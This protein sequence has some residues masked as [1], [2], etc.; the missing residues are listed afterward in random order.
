MLEDSFSIKHNN[1]MAEIDSKVFGNKKL[2]KAEI[3]AGFLEE[4]KAISRKIAINLIKE[5]WKLPDLA[6]D[7]NYVNE[8]TKKIVK[9]FREHLENTADSPSF[10]QH[11]I[12]RE[13]PDCE[14][15]LNSITQI[16]SSAVMF[17]SMEAYVRKDLWGQDENG[18]AYLRHLAKGYPKNYIEHYIT[19]PGDITLLP[20]DEAQ[21]IIDKFGFT[22]AKL[23]LVFAAHAMNQEKPWESQFNLKV[24]DII[25]EFGWDKNHKKSKAEKLREIA[26]TAFALDCLLV[27][28]VWVEGRNRKG[29]IIASAPVGRMWNI[30][31]KPTGQLNLDGEI[32]N[33]NDIYITVQPGLWTRD[34]LNRAGAIS[35]EALYQFGYLA[36]QVLKIDPYHNELALRLAIFLTLDSRVRLN[37]NYTVQELL[38]IAFPKPVIAQARQKRR[39]AYDL[40]QCWDSAIKLLIQLDW[41][42]EFD[43]TTYPEELR[44]DSTLQNPRG[45]L[46]ILLNARLTIKPPAP[47]PELL[48]AKATPKL[49]PS[50]PS[51]KQKSTPST[52][53]TGSQV[54]EA[55][56]AKGWSQAQLAGFLGVSQYLISLIERGQRPINQK[57]EPKIRK[58]LEI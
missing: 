16:P 5:N 14:K 30:Y 38:E 55:R 35:R 4:I 8:L 21:Q 17:S 32:D 43:S 49:E 11:E 1:L 9:S 3:E 48:T 25:Q 6:K 7:K 37:G 54:R 27:K 58:I 41:Q 23:H 53:L 34:F 46:D 26:S 13:I 47:I 28:A 51:S 2:L 56:A 19:R 12:Q 20:W 10:I 44:P 15:K 45:Y 31:I 40:K 29:Q 24:S 39:K 36:Q 22:T 50:S 42:I 57:I 33:L 52:N 18:I